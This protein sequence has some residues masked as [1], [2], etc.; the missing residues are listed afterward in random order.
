MKEF[1][2][3]ELLELVLKLQEKYGMPAY[4]DGN[5]RVSR[6]N[7][8]FWV[9]LFFHVH[10]PVW[11]KAARRFYYY[12]E[13]TGL[14]QEMEKL[15]M[16]YSFKQIMLNFSR[17]FWG[18]D[19]GCKCSLRDFRDIYELL[20]ARS[21]AE[22]G[23]FFNMDAH[24]Q[25]KTIH[26]KNGVLV[27]NEKKRKW[28]LSDFSPEFRSRNRCEITYDENAS[29][30]RFLNELIHRVMSKEDAELLLLYFAQ[31]FLG[32]NSSQTIL[33]L[34]G[35][36]GCGKTTAGNLAEKLIGRQNCTELRLEH[37][38]S[39]FELQRM[40]GK[41]LLAG[42]DVRSDF[43]NGSSSYKLK[44]LVGNDMMTMEAKGLNEAVDIRG[45]FNVMITSNS[46][47]CVKLDGDKKA[48]RR[49]LLIIRFK[50]VPPKTPIANFDDVLLEAEGSG[51]LNLILAASVKLLRSGGKI[52]KTETQERR[53]DD[54]L[55]ESD[56][57]NVFIEECVKP[58][59]GSTVASSEMLSALVKYYKGRD[60]KMLPTR[61]CRV[62]LVDAMLQIHNAVRRTDIMR[63]GKSRRGYSGFTLVLPEK[64]K[65]KETKA[66]AL[67]E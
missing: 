5:D 22:H 15:Q 20:I 14:W 26:C 56:G 16:L 31:C 45:S 53:V 63:N 17:A 64:E 49:R 32:S 33:I 36:G 12:E 48:W 7:Y 60:W 28:I 4:F 61:T 30:P 59:S 38:S 3:K 9:N 57:V 62:K 19:V 54:L 37:A 43:L 66:L 42:K 10:N 25:N 2:D 35:P 51:I 67:C 52:H 40:V 44:A 41:T 24:A 47:L 50:D 23:D 34:D 29:C 18:Q 58:A 65:S 6:V 11:D 46:R 13:T 8:T 21:N 27:Y 1:T 39:R 55:L